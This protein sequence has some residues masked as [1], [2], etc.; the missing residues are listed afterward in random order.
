MSSRAAKPIFVAE[1]EQEFAQRLGARGA[2]AAGFGRAAMKLALDAVGV[3]GGHVLVPELICTQVTEAVRRAG[4]RPVFYPVER[5]LAIRGESLA[6][7]LAPQTRAAVVVHYYGRVQPEMIALAALCREREV[8]CIEDCAMALGASLSGMPA[9]AFGD[10]GVFSF[11]KSDW[12]DGGGMV[13][14]HR[15]DLARALDAAS[16]ELKEHNRLSFRYGMLRRADYV[17]NRP[18]WSRVAEQAGRVLQRWCFPGVSDFYEAGRFDAAMPDFTARR[19]TRIVRGLAEAAQRRRGIVAAIR[20]SLLPAAETALFQGLFHGDDTGDSCA[21][22]LLRCAGAAGEWVDYAARRGVT[23]R[24]M[25]PAYQETEPGQDAA[26]LAMWAEG[27]VFMEVSPHLT[28]REV[29]RISGVLG[30][31]APKGD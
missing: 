5:D 20:E 28:R 29:E 24:R 6:A 18:R 30:A 19:A 10:I 3:A 1:F 16:A 22:L 13:T 31:L 9:G 7:A 8:A 11:T 27:I 4:A 23:L 21:F 26:R 12:C 17:A 2:V 14:A 25:W 15:A